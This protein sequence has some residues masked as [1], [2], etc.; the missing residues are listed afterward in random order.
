MKRILSATILILSAIALTACGSTTTTATPFDLTKTINVYTRDTTSGTRDAFFNGIALE[1]AVLDNEPLVDTYI[2]VDGNGSMISAVMNDVYGIG[3]ISLGSLADSGLIGLDYEGIQAS[4]AHVLDGSYTLK[5]PFNYIVRSD[6]T[7]MTTE[8]EIVE[9]FIAYMSTVDGKATIQNKHGIVDTSVTDPLWDDIKAQYDV[10]ANDNSGITINF[11]GST[12]VESIAK[13][14]SAEFS[15]KCGGFIAEHNH[16]GSGDAYKRVQ[17]TE[18]EGAN[19]LHIGFA[20]R[21]FKTTEPAV[22]GTSGQICWDAVVIVVNPA[23]TAVTAITAAELRRIY[24]GVVTLWN[25][26]NV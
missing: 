26:V 6:W 18:A 2:E 10:C 24:E 4:V 23:N 14:L 5:R 21:A 3:Y 7:G 12:S 17:G 25:D 9:A 15:V 19:M 8:Q 22:V 13:A 1:A 11:G 16:T 20:S